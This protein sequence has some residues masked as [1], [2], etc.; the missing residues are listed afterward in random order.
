[1][2]ERTAQIGA[3][4]ALHA[5]AATGFPVAVVPGLVLMAV[6]F[7]ADVAA[8]AG[9]LESLEPVAHLAGVLGMVLVW[10]A[11]V[12]GGVRGTARLG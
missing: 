4:P 8:H 2:N 9:A 1:M 6:A 10:I 12:I 5:D 3:E 11:V 7:L